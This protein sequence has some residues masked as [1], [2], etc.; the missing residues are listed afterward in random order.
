MSVFDFI[1]FCCA[2]ASRVGPASGVQ[3]FAHLYQP[4]YS[5]KHKTQNAKHNT[6][7][8]LSTPLSASLKYVSFPVQTLFKSSKIIPVM[9]MGRLLKDTRY[10]LSQYFEAFLIT[11]GVF[12][13]STFSK[14]GR[15]GNTEVW[16]IICLCVYIC[17]DSF[18]SQWQSRI[19]QKY[20]KSNVDQYQ[21][22]LGVNR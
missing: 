14:E 15:E 21:M 13:F 7:A 17:S 22:M 11:L 12:I 18:T 5:L 10:P 19:Y 3:Q 9:L 16:G 4:L 1:I 8:P 2:S 20:G 6:Y